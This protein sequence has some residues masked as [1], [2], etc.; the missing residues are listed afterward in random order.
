M[1]DKVQKTREVIEKRYEYWREKE[2]N[3]HSIESEIRMSECQHLLLML[4]SLQEESVSKEL[5]KVAEDYALDDYIKPWKELVKRAF[6]DG[7]KWQ[8]EQIMKEAIDG[9]VIEDIEEGNGD[10][11]LSCEYLPKNMG[12]VDKQKVKVIV[13]KEVSKRINKEL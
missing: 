5:E 4:N 9:Y 12:L 6:K 10:F 11:L 2:L 13:I 7:A 3:S 8:K 1:T